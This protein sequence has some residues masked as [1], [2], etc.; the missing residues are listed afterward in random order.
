MNSHLWKIAAVLLFSLPGL[1]T[2]Q[3]KAPVTTSDSS[4]DR[5]L[6]SNGTVFEGQI[7]EG[8]KTL[9]D[10]PNRYEIILKSGQTVSIEDT[11]QIESIQMDGL[12]LDDP[13]NR[14]GRGELLDLLRDFRSKHSV[15]E[16]EERKKSLSALVDFVLGEAS[17]VLSGS[18]QPTPLEKGSRIF[19]GEEVFASPS[20][21]VRLYVSGRLQLGIEEASSLKVI[22]IKNDQETGKFAFE[23]VLNRGS[24]WIDAPNNLQNKGQVQVSAEGLR[25]ELAEGLFRFEMNEAGDLTLAHFRGPE[26][27]IERIVDGEKVVCPQETRYTF[28]KDM[29]EGKTALDPRR[30]RLTDEN[31]WLEFT[32]WQPIATDV[33]V[34]FTLIGKPNMQPR[35]IVPIL[36]LATE[37]F[38]FQDLQPISLSGLAPLLQAYR[39]AL[40]R[41]DADVTR[42]PT[43]EEGL[44]ALR[45]APEG[46]ENWKGPYL[47]EN[48][49]ETDP[50]EHP[51]VYSVIETPAGRLT[52]LYSAGENGVDEQ[53]LGDDIR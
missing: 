35:P 30:E 44:K 52:E 39:A 15:L 12:L 2:A 36:G 19:T 34:Q 32:N 23:F 25:F 29:R 5:I 7:V 37:R 6:F 18:D 51:L 3:D 28:S 49:P 26:V 9:I 53:G 46:L 33:P 21:R 31:I 24:A 42:P 41:F 48:I 45:I 10:D 17:K 43:V 40:R 38:I 13:L 50:W 27:F 22:E 4:T 1:A 16:E 20:S 8:T 11:G 14:G 47:S